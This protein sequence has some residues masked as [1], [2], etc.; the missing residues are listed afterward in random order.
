MFPYSLFGVICRKGVKDVGGRYA[1]VAFESKGV[2]VV[3]YI[4]LSEDLSKCQWP[5]GAASLAVLVKNCKSLINF[6]M[7]DIRLLYRTG[8]QAILVT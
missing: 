8:K 6:E 2:A 4:W 7:F 5:S 3:P 1:V